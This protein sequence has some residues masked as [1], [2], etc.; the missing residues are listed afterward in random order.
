MA[1]SVRPRRSWLA[2]AYWKARASQEYFESQPPSRS[3]FWQR[4]LGLLW[5][6]AIACV[7][8]AP[9]TSAA[10]ESD[11]VGQSEDGRAV[12][13]IPRV[14]DWSY[15]LCDEA[16]TYAYRYAAWCKAHGGVYQGVYA[17]PDCVGATIPTTEST[18]RSLSLSFTQNLNTSASCS[19]SGDTGWGAT[20]TSNFCWNGQTIT[21]NGVETGTY[22]RIY[23]S[24]SNG[25][26][27]TISANRSRQL[28]CPV[29]AA[30]RTINGQTRCVMP[31]AP[32]C[33]CGLGNP[34]VPESGQKVQIEEDGTFEGF[35]LSRY[36]TSF[37]SLFESGSALDTQSV[38]ALWRDA[39][40][41]RLQPITTTTSVIAAL[42]FPNG[43]IQ[44]F[45]N[46]GSAVLNTDTGA[47]RLTSNGTGYDLVGDG[48]FLRFNAS[49]QLTSITIAGGRSY[50]LTY[51]DGTASGTT[52][53]VA[54]DSDGNQLGPVRAKQLLKVTSDSGRVLKFERD[55]AG[56]I[57]QMRVGASAPT[58]FYYSDNDLLTKVVYPGG[59]TRQYH[60]NESEQTGGA[61]L[62]YALTGISDLDASSNPVRYASYS[63]DSTGR[64]ITTQH[65]GGID[66]FDLQFNSSQT[67]Y[68]DP[69]GTQRTMTLTTIKGITKAASISQPAGSGSSAATQ[70]S[71][72]DV[73]GNEI[74]VDDYNGNRACKS[75]D[76]ARSLETLRVEGLAN[77]QACSGVV[78][79]GA[80][81][82]AGS[83]K[84]SV[85]WHPDWPL[86]VHVAEPGRLTT[87]VYNGQPD[88]FAGNA[89]ASCAPP[90]AALPNGR[91]IVVLCRRVEQATTDVDG[92][93]GFSATLRSGS[94]PRENKWTYNGRG[95]V[96][97]HDGPRTDVNDITTYAYY[98]DTTSD[99]TIGDLQSVTNAAGHVTQYTNYDAEGRLTRS[100]APNGVETVTTYT[101]RGWVNTV[102][103]TAG[104]VSQTTAYTYEQDGRIGT[105]SMPDGTTLSY[106]YDSAKRLTGII[107]G[108]GNSV[109]YTLDQAGNRIGE[110]YKDPSG[111]LARDISRVYDA[112][113]RL[114]LS[115][116]AA[117]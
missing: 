52:G 104:S 115:T 117:Q 105:V 108:V 34:I 96:L 9:L 49:G 103:I 114:I 95:Q 5:G 69:L 54:L 56:K 65:A 101:P 98:S 38:G 62:P 91:A 39:F 47:Y 53:Q 110:Q 86:E 111:N 55:V 61:S 8:S 70:T 77:T 116:G 18:L 2:F 58:R 19:I 63:Y 43:S 12:C 66:R 21:Q 106:S 6:V 94:L 44:Y 4:A 50:T 32:K 14:G 26:G 102:A 59:Q 67:V 24:C 51:S 41:Y 80:P 72:Y 29:G 81:L 57:T 37:G 11:C 22:R 112:V 3:P 68:T 16:G 36:Y 100:V 1:E 87:Y 31:I 60:Y 89:P 76:T 33:N 30:V 90:E 84:R 93:Q 75:Y 107:D 88:P 28:I 83:R 46:D 82:P 40:D 97:T 78:G 74:S 113:G 45:R 48:K 7:L 25:G 35:S 20:F 73:F 17:S 109:T 42:S 79:A 27:E 85:Q 92:S 10:A 99:H 64:A 15:G 13:S 71:A 23:T